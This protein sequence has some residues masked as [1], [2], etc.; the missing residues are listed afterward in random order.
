MGRNPHLVN[1]GGHLVL[2]AGGVVHLLGTGG[3]HL[4]QPLTDH[5]E[6]AW[7]SHKE[8]RP[9]GC[10]RIHH[11]ALDI[12]GQDQHPW[13]LPEPGDGV[14]HIHAI[15]PAGEDHI[16]HHRV[17][18]IPLD[19]THQLSSVLRFAYHLKVLLIRQRP[20]QVFPEFCPCIGHHDSFRV[21]HSSIFLS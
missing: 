14:Q 4:P 17:R 10:R 12:P 16:H 11:A 9:L 3:H 18:L 21:L 13:P 8:V 7:L 15:H 6:A 19:Q 20:Y 2:Q 5:A 1:D